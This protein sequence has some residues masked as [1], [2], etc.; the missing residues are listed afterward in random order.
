MGDGNFHRDRL[1]PLFFSGLNNPQSR[2]LAHN[3]PVQGLFGMIEGMDD[4]A[5]FNRLTAAAETWLRERGMQSVLGPLNLNIN[6]EPGLL[7]EGYETPP[8]FL[9]GHARPYYHRHLESTGYRSCQELLAYRLAPVYDEPEV[10]SR[11]RARVGKRLAQREF[12]R[13][14]KARE[15]ELLRGIF[16][17][18][19]SENWGFV[20][21]TRAEFKAIGNLLLLVV[22]RDFIRIAELD[23][24]PAGFIAVLPNI[25]ECIRDL[26]GRLFPTGWAKLLW[27]LKVAFPRT[28]R[29]PLMGVRKALHDTAFG[30]GIAV[31]MIHGMRAAVA[32]RG[33]TDTELSWI[34]R[35]NAGMRSILERLGGV[36]TKRYRLY[37]KSLSVS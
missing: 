37:E 4:A 1:R 18:A 16:N 29:V 27:R 5:V 26:N 24:E 23:G 6:Q 17:D 36:V 7:Y 14:D 9:L 31:T 13:A 32:G 11:L 33:V 12:N 22:P 3:N 2:D 20:P 15:L 21:F 25:N 30:P 8:S 10:M 28:A 19:W 34:L 35:D